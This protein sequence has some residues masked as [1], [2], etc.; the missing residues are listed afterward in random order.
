MWILQFTGTNHVGNGLDP[1]KGLV[2][3]NFHTWE[4]KNH[5]FS[6]WMSNDYSSNCLDLA[7]SVT[8][9]PG[10]SLRKDTRAGYEVKPGKNIK[11]NW[12]KEQGVIQGKTVAPKSHCKEENKLTWGWNSSSSPTEAFQQLLFVYTP[13]HLRLLVHGWIY[14]GGSVAILVTCPGPLVGAGVLFTLFSVP[15]H[16]SSLPLFA[17]NFI[18]SR[19]L[20]TL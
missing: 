1:G 3:G 19:L 10:A 20:Q 14:V 9:W 15:W 12:W 11:Y 18:L 13:V 2:L 17:S 4:T 6:S 7:T 8:D 16:G 5:Y